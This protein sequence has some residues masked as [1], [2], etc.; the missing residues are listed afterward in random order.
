MG[1]DPL[2][3]LELI[4]E[5]TTSFSRLKHG[6]EWNR[7]SQKLP[8]SPQNNSKYCF[9]IFCFGTS[10]VFQWLRLHASNT[11][12]MGSISGLGTKILTRCV[13]QLKKEKIN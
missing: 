1:H 7:N 6:I 8:S 9:K 4:G 13:V 2:L 10:L 12:G 5:V 3:G 11:V